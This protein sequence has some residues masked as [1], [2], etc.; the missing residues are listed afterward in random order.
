MDTETLRPNAAGDE[1][2]IRYQNPGSGSHYDKV[3][4]E[5]PDELTTCVFEYGAD[6]W[7]RDLYNIAD[8]S[9]GSG[10]INHIT[11]YAN[12]KAQDTPTQASL[13]IAIKSTNVHEG[14][15]ETLTTGW[16]NYSKQWATNPDNAHAWTWDEIDALQIGISLRRQQIGGLD[17]S[18]C[19]QVYV[20]VDYTPLVAA[21]RSFGFIMG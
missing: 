15:E 19:T 9:V 10:T 18:Y 16:A 8:H 6:T 21:G 17:A 4:E 1:T 7:L 2:N 13:K 11:V 14:S 3:D 5:T 12:C 20:V